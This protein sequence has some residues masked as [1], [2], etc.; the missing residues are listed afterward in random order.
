M[1]ASLHQKVRIQN[2]VKKKNYKLFGMQEKYLMFYAGWIAALLMNAY[3]FGWCFVDVQGY[4]IVPKADCPHA[5]AL[6]SC[7]PAE[8]NLSQA[9]ERCDEV[10]E[11]WICLHCHT[12]C[13]L[14]MIGYRMSQFA[15]RK[16]P[17]NNYFAVFFL[18]LRSKNDGPASKQYDTI[19]CY[20][21]GQVWFFKVP[22]RSPEMIWQ[23]FHLDVAEKK[24]QPC[25]LLGTYMYVCL[26]D[27]LLCL[28]LQHMGRFLFYC[29]F[30]LP[31][32]EQ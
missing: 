22:P 24:F 30:R 28:I 5:E 32:A 8:I 15:L 25:S 7:V 20:L 12:V 4:L 9:C 21:F 1:R 11:N 13:Q 10:A 18:D 29:S 2:I 14:E 27:G 6:E 16:C 17:L 3:H 31:V 26:A 23:N 19:M